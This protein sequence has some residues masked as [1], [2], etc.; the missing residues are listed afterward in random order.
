MADPSGAAPQ[1][2]PNDVSTAILRPKKS[3]VTISP[4]LLAVLLIFGDR[5]SPNRL[6]VDEATSDDSSGEQACKI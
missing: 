1:P 5:Y 2:G 4:G 6:I 3:C